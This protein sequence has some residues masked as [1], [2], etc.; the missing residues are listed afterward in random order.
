MD[1]FKW[2]PEQQQYAATAHTVPRA[3]FVRDGQE[4]SDTRIWAAITRLRIAVWDIH[5]D[6]P[7]RREMLRGE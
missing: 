6:G 3:E 1:H 2:T 4:E 7:A 5:R